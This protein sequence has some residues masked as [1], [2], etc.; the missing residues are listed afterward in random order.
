MRGLRQNKDRDANFMKENNLCR[1][2]MVGAS[3]KNWYSTAWTLWTAG[4]LKLRTG[5]LGW[6]HTLL[7]YGGKRKLWGLSLGQWL[8]VFLF[9]CLGFGLSSCSAS[10]AISAAATNVIHEASA[11]KIDANEIIT[12]TDQ[13]EV[14]ELAASID[15]HQDNIID[16]ADTVHANITGIEDS[17]P[18]WGK[19][20]NNLA[21]AGIVLGVLVL[22]WYTGIGSLIK[23]FFWALGLFIPRSVKRDVELDRE[24]I[25]PKRNTTPREAVAA[26]RASDPAYDAAW[27]K[28]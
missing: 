5:F 10:Q 28:S 8:A 25:D 9:S 16:A 26:R 20:M 23:R 27:R 1:T 19:M 17:V 2:R 4:C 21:Y 15:E 24:A 7:G 6:I 13:V 14:A 3:I 12:K 22:L 11:S 18:W